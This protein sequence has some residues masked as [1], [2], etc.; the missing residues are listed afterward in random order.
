MSHASRTS[1]TSANN[2]AL[3]LAA[4]LIWKRFIGGTA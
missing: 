1:R 4:G 3:S 2:A